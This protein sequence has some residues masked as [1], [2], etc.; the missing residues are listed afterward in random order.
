MLNN[1]AKK[2]YEKSVFLEYSSTGGYIV[3]KLFN[4][5]DKFMETNTGQLQK[6]FNE[7]NE[8]SRFMKVNFITFWN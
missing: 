8:L 3:C 5:T 2:N 6:I 4:K 1:C 7:E